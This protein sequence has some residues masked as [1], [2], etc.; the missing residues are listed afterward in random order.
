MIPSSPR[1]IPTSSLAY[2]PRTTTPPPPLPSDILPPTPLQA[3]AWTPQ[4]GSI[5][6]WF[7]TLRQVEAPERE[8]DTSVP[9]PL[10]LDQPDPDAALADPATLLNLAPKTD[11]SYVIVPRIGVEHQDE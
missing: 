3:Q 4:I 6:D 11:G 10:R 7:A 8:E 2:Y 9:L 5:V 1:R